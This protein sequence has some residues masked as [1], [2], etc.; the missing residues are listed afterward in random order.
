METE[1]VQIKSKDYE[2]EEKIENID[3]KQREKGRGK[4]IIK[5]AMK[6]NRGERR[7]LE[8]DMSERH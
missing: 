1:I 6:G 3:E 4:W 8:A 7:E 2:G 5:P